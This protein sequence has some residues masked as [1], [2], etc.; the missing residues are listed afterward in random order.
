MKIGVITNQGDFNYGNKMQLYAVITIYR[1]LGYEPVRLILDHPDKAIRHP[2]KVL[3]HF[4]ERNHKIISPENAG[5]KPSARAKAFS[6][7]NDKIPTC[8]I[9]SLETFDASSYDYFSVG[10][11]Q[12]WNPNYSCSM[13]PESTNY[14]KQMYHRLVDPTSF[15]DASRWWF[16]RFAGRDQRIALA[17]SIGVDTLS[18]RQTRWLKNGVLGFDRLSVREAEGA[19]LIQEC[20]GR[21]ATVICDPSLVLT[22][23]SWSGV[24]DDR[25]TPAEPYVFMYLL[26]DASPESVRALQL[27]TRNG[28]I[29]VVSLSDR[30]RPNEPAAGPA[31]FI[32]LVAHANA[33]VTDSFHASVFSSIFERPLAI[34]HRAGDSTQASIFSRLDSLTKMLGIEDKVFDAANFDF[35][36]AADYEGVADAI[37]CERGRFMEYL[38]GCLNG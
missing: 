36:M 7:F 18:R 11:D 14:A 2:Q 38:E 1:R 25:I 6:R 5:I 30:N 27:M 10:S 12:V 28:E 17:P 8:H 33:V 31:E 19:K 13:L 35:S 24:A 21:S 23:C 26:G 29:P 34:V 32:S 9:G 20:S 22:K 37:N 15:T 4:L 3:A 16:L